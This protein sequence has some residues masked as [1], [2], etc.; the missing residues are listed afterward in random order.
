MRR[1]KILF[2][3]EG[4]FLPT[5]YSVYTNQILSRLAA[6]PRFEVAELACY[7]DTEA[8]AKHQ[9]DWLIFPNQPPKN[10]EDWEFY[11]SNPS[12]EFGDYTFNH[13]LLEFMPDFVMDIRDWWMFEF[14]QRSPFRY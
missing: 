3:S 8:A 9:K 1:K 4:H 12:Y 10:A 2:C 13:V 11:K 7:T 14:Q 5:G 6:D